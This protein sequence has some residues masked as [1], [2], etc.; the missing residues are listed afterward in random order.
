MRQKQKAPTLAGGAPGLEGVT[1]SIHTQK[2]LPSAMPDWSGFAMIALA[3]LP[4]PSAIGLGRC[5]VFLAP[6]TPVITLPN[7]SLADFLYI[8]T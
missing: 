3:W 1:R 7:Y 5:L 6:A 2:P 8:A 4:L